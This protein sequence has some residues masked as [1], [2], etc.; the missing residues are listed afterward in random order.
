MHEGSLIASLLGHVAQLAA[1]HSAADVQA[2]RLEIGPLA[3]VEP[4]LLQEAFLRQR[5]GT[6]AA[7]AELVIDAV[8]LTC[9]CRECQLNFSTKDIRARCPDCAASADI[10]A[11]DAVIL[12][13]VQLHMVEESGIKP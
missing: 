9:R 11:G 7:A 8:E 5:E 10:L 1:S 6:I 12:E 2:I 4:L 13:S 3:G